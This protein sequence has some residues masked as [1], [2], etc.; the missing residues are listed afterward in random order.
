[1]EIHTGN[2]EA[3]LSAAESRFREHGFQGSTLTEITGDAGVTTGS[4]YRQFSSK[5]ELFS[6]L[7]RRHVEAASRALAAAKDVQEAVAGWI[8]HCREHAGTIVVQRELV[9]PSSNFVGAW[10]AARDRW[11]HALRILLPAGLRSATAGAAAAIALSLLEYYTYG[12]LRGWFPTRDVERVSAAIAEVLL[13]G[14]YPPLDQQLRGW[15]PKES[16]EPVVYDRVILWDP[17]PGKAVPNSQRGRETVDRIEEEAV[18]IFF[19]KGYSNSSMEDVAEAAGVSTGTVYRYFE[20]KED[21]F[22]LLLS[23]VEEELVR[24]AVHP[25]MPDGRQSVYQTAAGFLSMYRDH[26]GLY[27]VWWELIA[28]RTRYEDEWVEFH[29]LHEKL[30]ERVLRA[31]RRRGLLKAEVDIEIAVE[32]YQAMHEA[33]A[34]DRIILGREL[35]LPDRAVTE[36][37]EAML[38]GGL[39]REVE[40]ASL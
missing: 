22:R 36:C 8:E 13:D 30:M 21:L 4:F 16:A 26:V 19:S 25:P 32:L 39:D 3:I 7:Y 12:E 2:A 9:Q 1:M 24:R 37:M 10:M 18:R 33:V 29:Q 40:G 20:D 11:E 31:N 17:A 35:A 5:D 23:E 14:W 38:N 28:K 6:V 15:E 27:R 34:Y